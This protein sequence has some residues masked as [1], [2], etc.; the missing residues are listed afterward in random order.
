M[1][2]KLRGWRRLG[3]LVLRR[4]LLL[5]LLLLLHLLQLLQ[6]L[7][8]C[9]G[10]GLLLGLG[11]L[12]WLLLLRLLLNLGQW[13]PNGRILW[14]RIAGSLFVRSILVVSFALGVGRP[15]RLCSGVS[16]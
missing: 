16:R 4:G 2:L 14:L 15:G 1:S 3:R 8:R 7:L 6:Q 11:R 12:L 13:R 9:L 10:S 5:L